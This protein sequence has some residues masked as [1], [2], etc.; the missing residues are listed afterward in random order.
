[1]MGKEVILTHGGLEKLE[2]ELEYLKT[3][4]RREVADRIKTAISFG[5][6]SE[7]SEYE[8]AKNEQAFVEGRIIT[9][10]KMLRNARII[11]KAENGTDVVS[12]GSTVILK[13]L[14]Y[15]EDFE[16]TIVGTAE[17]NPA[18]NKISNESPVGKAILGKKINDVVEVI[19]PAGILK[20]KIVSIS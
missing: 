6:I 12:I 13:D 16:Y 18:E 10:E 11:D 7:N 15:D 5:D 2:K 9:L 3:I 14:E 20:Y 8:D 19:V 17:A 1:M 4:K